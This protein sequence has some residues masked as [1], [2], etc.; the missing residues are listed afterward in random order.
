[1][2]NYFEIVYE[3]NKS[4]KAQINKINQN[5]LRFS[6]INIEFSNLLI[7]IQATT[8]AHTASHIDNSHTY[9]TKISNLFMFANNDRIK[10]NSFLYLIKSKIEENFD[11]F[12]ISTK[13]QV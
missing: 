1:M 13:I 2:Q 7:A 8:T 10:I 9:S 5:N 4:L 6:Q 11:Y 3:K 12:T